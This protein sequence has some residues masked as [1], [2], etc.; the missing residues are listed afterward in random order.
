MSAS[1]EGCSLTPDGAGVG[2]PPSDAVVRAR[3]ADFA[4]ERRHGC[5][6]PY[7]VINCGQA[8]NIMRLP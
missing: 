2:D 7:Q 6:V 4:V 8:I 3:T 1:V 5:R